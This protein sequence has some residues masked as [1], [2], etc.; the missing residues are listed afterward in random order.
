[1]NVLLE[2]VTRGHETISSLFDMNNSQLNGKCGDTISLFE[3]YFAVFKS[4][5][6][7]SKDYI[8]RPIVK[9]HAMLFYRLP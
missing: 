4:S 2:Q 7:V 5:L 8:I 1:M 3:R 9:Y 6:G